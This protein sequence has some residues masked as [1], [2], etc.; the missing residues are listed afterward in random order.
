MT[1]SAIDLEERLTQLKKEVPTRG[2]ERHPLI[3][4][5]VSDLTAK[6]QSHAA[7]PGVSAQHLAYIRHGNYS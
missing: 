6:L 2:F 7:F 1:T 3:L 5:N 4:K